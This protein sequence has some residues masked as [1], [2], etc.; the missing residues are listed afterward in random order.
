MSASDFFLKMRVF[1]MRMNDHVARKKIKKRQNRFRRK[2]GK[3]Y[4]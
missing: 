1:P 3:V 2:N 4:Y